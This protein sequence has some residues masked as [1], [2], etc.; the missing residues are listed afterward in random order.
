MRCLSL[1]FIF[2]LIFVLTGCSNNE[3]TEKDLLIENIE[4]MA[5][6]P[7]FEGS[8]TG[9]ALIET[10]IASFLTEHGLNK[11]QLNNA[12]VSEIVLSTDD[13]TN[14]DLFQSITLQI[15]SDQTD[16]I[17]LGLINPIEKNSQSLTLKIAE[18]QEKLIEVLKQDNV[19]IIADAIL[20][21]DTDMGLKFKCKINFKI[22]HQ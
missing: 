14:F 10:P 16:M 13:S 9:Q 4:I 6:G 11:E 21:Q 19:Y 17:K 18:E 12:K 8:N 7:L 15:V 20:N 2:T 1:P 3:S 5:E 22:S